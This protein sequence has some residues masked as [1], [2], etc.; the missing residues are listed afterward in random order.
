MQQ[1]PFFPPLFN[2][3]QDGNKSLRCR[4]FAAALDALGSGGEAAALPGFF[5]RIYPYLGVN[6]VK[7]EFQTFLERGIE[8]EHQN[9]MVVINC[10]GGWTARA[11]VD[12]RS[13][14]WVKIQVFPGQE[15]KDPAKKG[16]TV[17]PTHK[18]PTF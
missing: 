3:V 10:R 4:S 18:P 2:S 6:L 9:A 15:D 1:N 16:K 5:I 11:E 12:E 8:S 17:H 13:H 14:S 7:E